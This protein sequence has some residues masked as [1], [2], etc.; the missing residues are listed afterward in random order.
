VGIKTAAYFAATN[1]DSQE[2]TVVRLPAHTPEKETMKL[3]AYATSGTSP[4][5]FDFVCENH[6]SIFLL[7]AVSPSAFAWIE[8]HLPPD[9]LTFGNAVVIEPRY[10]WA[11]LVGLQDDGLVVTRG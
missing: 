6:F 8:E 4:T 11:I 2:S 5:Q 10:V 1:R 7:H 3:N 9:R